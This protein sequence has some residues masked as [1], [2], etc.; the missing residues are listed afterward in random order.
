MSFGLVV[1]QGVPRP[2]PGGAVGLEGELLGQLP[3]EGLHE[4]PV[5][6][7]VAPVEALFRAVVEGFE[8]VQVP[9]VFVELT[10]GVS[11]EV[12]ELRV[13]FFANIMILICSINRPLRSPA[14][15]A[16]FPATD[17]SWLTR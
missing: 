15:P 2:G 7:D 4:A 14:R 6:E 1:P 11:F 3:T 10:A 17:R 8:G 13:G 16:L 12:V 9:G 5:H